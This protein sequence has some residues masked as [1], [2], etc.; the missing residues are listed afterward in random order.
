[1]Q[2]AESLFAALAAED[3]EENGEEAPAEEQ[4]EAEAPAKKDKKKKKGGAESLFAA[5][6]Q[7]DGGC[8]LLWGFAGTTV[9]DGRRVAR[10]QWYWRGEGRDCRAGEEIG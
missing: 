1:M 9:F 3:G 2:G 6:E 4:E 7:A 8:G 10:F 5:L